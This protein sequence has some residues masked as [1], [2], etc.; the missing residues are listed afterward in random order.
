MGEK[1]TFNSVTK[2]I[3]VTEAPDVNDEIYIDVKTD[4]YSDGKEDWVASEALRK[5]TFPISAVGGNPLP[6]SK[7]LGSTF[8]I[9]SDWKI[10]PYEAS[11]RLVI[12]GNF[13]SQDGEDPFLDTVGTYTVRI[14]QQVSSLVDSTVQQLSE[15]EYSS[16]QDHVWIDPDSDQ[17]GTVYP[18]GN[19]EHPVNNLIDAVAIAVE[20]GLPALGVLKPMTIGD[21]QD[22]V[23]YTIRGLSHVATAILIDTNAITANITIENCKVSGILDGGSH[24]LRSQ[25]ED[26]TYVNGHIH[27]C[28]LRGDVGLDGGAD[29]VMEDCHMVDADDPPVIDMG[30]TGQSLSMPNYSGTVT[31]KNL[32]D[33]D[34]EITVGLNAGRVILD[35]TITAGTIEVSGSGTLVD[36]STGT[37]IVNSDGLMSTETITR[38]VW[39]EP[40]SSHIVSGSFGEYISKIPLIGKLIALIKGL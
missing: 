28:G 21:S 38:A 20:R 22:L 31:I 35:S 27:N 4:L 37:A 8:F 13:Y 39:D 23:G 33:T 6:G 3:T 25:I 34:A 12:N 5:V 18:S 26:L 17:T 19:R 14:M 29:A 16:F 32:S 9:R 36:N 24:I 11:H 30:D 7:E 10:C 1:V 40:T 2:R 15:L